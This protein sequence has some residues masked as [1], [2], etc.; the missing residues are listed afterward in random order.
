MQKCHRLVSVG[1]PPLRKKKQGAV[2]ANM[3]LGSKCTFSDWVDM[4]ELK[5]KM[6]GHLLREAQ[7]IG[8]TLNHSV[9]Q[10]GPGY[11]GTDGAET[12]LRRL[13]CL[14]TAAKH[15]GSFKIASKL[16]ELPAD[17]AISEI[18][19]DLLTEVYTR[20]KLEEKLETYRNK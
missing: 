13:L 8:R 15:G 6:T 11:L 2:L 18:P 4:Y 5:F 20:I 7:T 19:E 14:V 12:L 9:C 16:E 3:M 17:D 10:L 1:V